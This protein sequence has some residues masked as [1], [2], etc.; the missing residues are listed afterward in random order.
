MN[1]SI[2]FLLK[3]ITIL[4]LILIFLS[5]YLA[6]KRSR[7][8][9]M[10]KGIKLYIQ[11][12]QDK[13]CEYFTNEFP[14]SAELI[15][16]NEIEI[17]A[18]EEIFLSY[19]QNLS[20]VGIK[21]RIQDFSNEYLNQYYKRL[22]HSK[23]WSLRMN[24]MYRIIDFQIDSLEDECK[25]M[26][27][28]KLSQDERFQLLVIHSNFSADTFLKEFVTLSIRFSEYEYK[29]L[30]INIDS[31]MLQELTY[32]TD[33]LPVECQ[34]SLIDVLGIRHDMEFSPFLES[35]L[36]SENPEIRIR[37]LRAINE[38][39]IVTK[40]DN[41]M[42]FLNSSLW[43]ERLMMARILRNFPLNQVHPYLEKLLKDENW[44]VRSQA[45]KTIGDS[46]NGKEKLES[47]IKIGQ[48]KY[49]T[50]LA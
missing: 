17:K 35:N 43:E 32:Q 47:Y 30:L 7:E 8:I 24:A 28:R 46:R 9:A 27:E 19:I 11:N 5:I 12:K 13:W 25:K 36:K 39:G 1:I 22:L 23:R 38:I 34:Y 50:D 21:K 49:A 15:P 4:S 45:S 37:S 40:L 42:D 2:D 33:E 18:I 31:E 44:W 48:E 14:L 20:N 6:F 10:N 26:G 16:R 3:G 41:Y 29:K